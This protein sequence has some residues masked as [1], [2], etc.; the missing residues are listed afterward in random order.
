[1]FLNCFSDKHQ[2]KNKIEKYVHRLIVMAEIGI[3]TQEKIIW[4]YSQKGLKAE[5]FLFLLTRTFTA[6]F[7]TGNSML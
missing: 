3:L 7:Q 5:K 1:M 4:L 6:T 2:Y